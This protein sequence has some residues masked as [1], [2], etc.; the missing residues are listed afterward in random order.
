MGISLDSLSITSAF[1]SILNFFKSQENN[2]K[3]KD[4]STGS[5]G[6]FLIRM[7]AN[8][9][10]NISYRLVTAR[11]E[12]YITTANLLS[13]SLG[14]ALNLGYSAHRG[15]NQ[16]RKIEFEANSDYIVPSHTVIGSYDGDYDVIYVGDLDP[17]THL[18]QGLI[19]TGPL[20]LD[21][22]RSVDSLT[23]TIVINSD[24]SDEISVGE[25]IDL[26]GT[27]TPDGRYTIASINTK[28]IG[29]NTYTYVM[30]AEPISGSYVNPGNDPAKA[31]RVVIQD[32]KVVIGK[33]K[34]ITWT[35]GTS[36]VQPFTRFEEGISEDYILYLDG[37]EVP[38]SNIV[39]D[40][41]EDMYLVRTNPYSS[42]DILY[43]NNMSTAQHKYGSESVFTLK[44][45]E[46]ADVETREF[47]ANMSG[48][49]TIKSTVTISQYTP[50]EKIDDIK[51]N[52]PVDHEVQHLI[53][54]KKD[55]TRR[56]KQILPNITETSYQAVTPT[57]TV[58]TYLKDDCTTLE[59][60][61]VEKV[62]GILTNENY[63][64]TPLPDISHPSREVVNITIKVYITNKLIDSNDIRYDIDNII[65][66]NYAKYLNQTFDTYTLE[67][68]IEQLSY[69]KWARVSVDSGEWTSRGV[70]DLGSIIKV[71]GTY[72]KASKILGYSGG[73]EPNWNIPLNT[74]PLGVDL[75]EVYETKDG[76]VIWRAYKRLD[77]EDIKEHKTGTQYGIGDYVYVPSFPHFMFKCI[78]LLKSS[79]SS[80]I[81]TTTTEKGDFIIDGELVWVCKEY[82]ASYPTRLTAY[83]YRMGASANIGSK[84]FEVIGYV[85]KT[86]YTNPEFEKVDY[87][88]VNWVVPKPIVDFT[89]SPYGYFEL[90]GDQT[91]YYR[92]GSQ[93]LA[94][95]DKDTEETAQPFTV[96]SR[97][98]DNDTTKVY[99]TT[100]I[101]EYIR[102]VH[103]ESYGPTGSGN[104]SLFTVAGDRT[105]MFKVGDTIKALGDSID[106]TQT[107]ITTSYTYNII[108]V[109]VVPNASN[110]GVNTEI[111]IKD[112][113]SKDVTYHT[114]IEASYT[115]LS[116]APELN[117]S[118]CVEGDV[119]Q[120]F[121]EGDI[122]KT[123]TDEDIEMTY[124]V[125]S[126]TYS[127]MYNVTY[128]HVVQTISRNANYRI[129]APAWQGTTD[130]EVKWSILED[131]NH[132]IYGW[133][134]Y[135]DI[136]TK[137]MLQY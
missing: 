42:V 5:E 125:S 13:S 137:I 10:S 66:S 96:L 61:E 93:V 91:E 87:D 20:E 7:L 54:S 39:R 128:I 81:D 46:S 95:K 34:T 35:A 1:N 12:N 76:N 120:F 115:R 86:G 38:T 14:I 11:R 102:S 112:K 15:T 88:I 90:E 131:I 134:V 49:G 99:V 41:K 119:T 118:F 57:Y 16:K 62:K 75:D 127:S 129:I 124:T 110:T 70:I 32:F 111:M 89:L 17:D 98:T 43:L 29:N 84:S 103:V 36:K 64:G 63:F 130:G 6:I 104:T 60:Q 113:L 58:I 33:L 106:G 30:T 3:W 133:D 27:G 24:V 25:F 56:V 94:Y 8:I 48:Y 26:E 71:G 53:R 59:N 47:D 109:R 116:C 50:F 21:I 69:V 72:Y 9:L 107:S 78:D 77:V 65:K 2:S 37:E 80:S 79:G 18:R 74:K 40:L 135:N 108:D 73:T 51:V 100:S 22:V 101:G 122:V 31:I 45:I 136:N 85:G 82:N 44:Y 97:S 23:R 132:I 92:V 83:P 117:N 55:Y 105:G 68:L 52:A 4:L 114:L 126:S 28:A 123:K 67:R 121:E 19:L